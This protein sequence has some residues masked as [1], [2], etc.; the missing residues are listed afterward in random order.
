MVKKNKD[1]VTKKVSISRKRKDGKTVKIKAIKTSSKPRTVKKKVSKTPKKVYKKFPFTKKQIETALDA[2]WGNVAKAARL[3]KYKDGSEV[4]RT[5]LD[6]QIIS[7]GL[8]YYAVNS[9]KRIAKAAFD[10]VQELGIN[11]RDYKCLFKILDTW[12]KYIDFVEPGK[13]VNVNVKDGFDW[14]EFLNNID[15]QR[16]K[17][18][19]REAESN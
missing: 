14:G 15:P 11:G 13:E 12:G 4:S 1:V 5:T 6:G 17:K 18:H 10:V 16:K 2:T 8:K 7:K 3:L 19:E 9:R